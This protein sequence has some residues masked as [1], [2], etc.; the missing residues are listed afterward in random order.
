MKMKKIANYQISLKAILKNSAWETLI[1]KTWNEFD[2]P[3][4]KYDFPGWRIDENEFEVAY[5]DILR[6][7]IK[8]ELWEKVKVELNKKPV[9]IWRHKNS[10][11]II[12]YVVFEWNILSWDVEISH[13]HSGYKFI[14]LEW[15]VL[16]DYFKSWMLE[17]AKMYLEK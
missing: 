7:E 10:R 16:E 15:I 8:E 17:V 5:L 9:A 14:K 13:E 6:R 1:L 4:W 3:Y 12:F 2:N 11:D